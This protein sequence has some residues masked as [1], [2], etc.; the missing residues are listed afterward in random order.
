MT[1]KNMSTLTI[2]TATGIF[3]TDNKL[4]LADKFLHFDSIIKDDS[5]DQIDMPMIDSY[6]LELLHLSYLKIR[7]LS[8]LSK[9]IDIIN[10]IKMAA[11][12]QAKP[13]FLVALSD[14][15]MTVD[16]DMIPIIENH[17]VISFDYESKET[18][19]VK[20]LRERLIETIIFEMT[21]FEDIK[22]LLPYLE[23]AQV[24]LL[25]KHYSI[26]WIELGD[27]LVD[28]NPRYNL[29]QLVRAHASYMQTR[30]TYILHPTFEA[31]LLDIDQRLRY[32]QTIEDI[33]ERDPRHN[34]V[35]Y[36]LKPGTVIKHTNLY[37]RVFER[38]PDFRLTSS[39]I[40]CTSD[41]HI[42]G[43]SKPF[44]LDKYRYPYVNAVM[45]RV[46]PNHVWEI[47]PNPV[48]FVD[49]DDL[50]VIPGWANNLDEPY[51]FTNSRLLFAKEPAV[52]AFL[53]Y[54][55][56][57]KPN[58]IQIYGYIRSLCTHYMKDVYNPILYC[59]RTTGNRKLYKLVEDAL[60]RR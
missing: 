3:V 44:Q 35:L 25:L 24:L 8:R 17:R 39:S 11:Y 30:H 4:I 53:D 10:Y 59:I 2:K 50:N 29:H 21:P 54:V 55:E 57:E 27:P 34:T 60:L 15:L 49:S 56:K 41:C 1:R 36:C 5:E 12:F 40:E 13:E 38:F 32:P 9:N 52:L 51:D 26:P 48:V 20:T 58:S 6:G 23:Y 18:L 42:P 19:F 33:I 7:E 46:E 22:V 37:N 31:K 16:N 47:I 14:C 28:F 43:H 45:C